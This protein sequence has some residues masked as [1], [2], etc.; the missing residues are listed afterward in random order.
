MKKHL[1]RFAIA[2]FLTSGVAHAGDWGNLGKG[3]APVV[4]HVDCLSYDYVDLEYIYTDYGTPKFDDGH[5]YGIGF[6]KS[7]GSAFFLTGS[8]SDSGYDYDWDGHIVDVDTRRYRMGLGTNIPLAKCVDFTFEGG[9]DHL[10]A[11]YTYHPDHDYDS[12]AYYFGPGIRARA[13]AF[14]VYAKI[15]YF[16][17]EGDLSQYYLSQHTFSHGRVDEDGWLFTPGIIYHFTDSFGLKV[18][19]EIDQYNTAFLLGARFHY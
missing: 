11:E 3:M 5:G 14:E 9:F 13:G 12:W 4:P 10:D 16:S 15:F 19:A 2:L 6:S 1:L 18:G 7:L 8:F 17:R